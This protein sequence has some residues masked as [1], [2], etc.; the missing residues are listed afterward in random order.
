MGSFVQDGLD[1][2]TYVRSTTR[3]IIPDERA[4]QQPPGYLPGCARRVFG[5][6]KDSI[7]LWLVLTVAVAVA[8]AVGYRG[9]REEEW[10][11]TNLVR[12][13]LTLTAEVGALCVLRTALYLLPCRTL[14]F[15]SEEKLPCMRM[16]LPWMR[17]LK[18]AT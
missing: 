16:C 1:T 13:G 17:S 14:S 18:V 8:V 6:W 15:R 4:D 3:V 12:C 10:N 2:Y 7:P 11:L 9:G 5:T